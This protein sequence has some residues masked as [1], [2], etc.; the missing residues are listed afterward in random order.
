MCYTGFTNLDQGKIWQ[1]AGLHVPR[2]FY[3]VE[4]LG[5]SSLNAN[6][7]PTVEASSKL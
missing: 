3:S 7:G 4:K 5:L 1:D 6:L 2:D